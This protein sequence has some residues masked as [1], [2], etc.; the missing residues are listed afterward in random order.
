MPGVAWGVPGVFRGRGAV[1]TGGFV[2]VSV[3]VGV[4]V[5]SGVADA[6]RVSAWGSA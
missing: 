5:G 3:G 2:G 1:I 4:G 6:R